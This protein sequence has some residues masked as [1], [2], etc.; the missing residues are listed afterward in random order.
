[1]ITPVSK[2]FTNPENSICII[3]INPDSEI[4]P[5]INKNCKGLY[6]TRKENVGTQ[7]RGYVQTKFYFSDK[8]DAASFKVTWG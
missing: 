4:W 5:W 6:T 1:M 8:Q 3:L 7:R 2:Y